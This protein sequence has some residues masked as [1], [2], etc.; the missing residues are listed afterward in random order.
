[1]DEI[2]NLANWGITM[3]QA[4]KIVENLMA[5]GSVEA[6]RKHMDVGVSESLAGHRIVRYHDF[7]SFLAKM[8]SKQAPTIIGRVEKQTV[9]L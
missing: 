9:Y 4:E 6:F 1:M 5:P 8:L 3:Q 7:S 2:T